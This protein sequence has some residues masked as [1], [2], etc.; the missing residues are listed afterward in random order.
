MVPIPYVTSAWDVYSALAV[1]VLGLWLARAVGRAFGLSYMLCLP[2]YLWHTAFCVLYAWFV[3]GDG[4]DSLMYY[5]A[6]LNDGVE[7]SFGTAGVIVFTSLFTQGLGLSFLGTFLVFNLAGYVGLLAFAGSLHQAI[8]ERALGIRLLALAVLFLPSMHYWGSAIGKDALSFLS[9]GLSL[10]A[11]LDLRR[12]HLLMVVAVMIMLVVRPHMAGIQLIALAAAFCL[13]PG[14]VLWQRLLLGTAALA[15]A[16]IIVPLALDYAGVGS[17][18]DADQVMSYIELRQ[19]YNQT[20]GGAVD[21]ASMSLPMQ[22]FTYMFRPLPMEASSV[23][24][25]ASSVDNV[26]LLYLMVVGG[27]AAIT[28][29]NAPP[30]NRLFLW[31]YLLLAWTIL[32]MTTA[33]LG[34]AARQKWMFTPV[35][36]YLLMSVMGRPRQ[37]AT[38]AESSGGSTPSVESTP[39]GVAR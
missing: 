26:I 27:I 13:Q 2:L 19:S 28:G 11:A 29:R 20:G 39:N 8:A 33:N 17:G 34:I 24:Q 16:A 18:S 21:I 32:A 38:D 10:W 14:V 31:F 7:F 30:A 5:R 15:G 1:F 35:L 12:R 37:T 3:N 22:L 9:M 6:S 25:L 36:I 4:G 23:F